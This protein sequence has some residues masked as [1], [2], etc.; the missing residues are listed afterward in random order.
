MLPLGRVPTVQIMTNIEAFPSTKLEKQ[1]T[2]WESGSTETGGRNAHFD[3]APG[4]TLW[5]TRGDFGV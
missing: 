1:F 5:G 4:L 3:L 2:E